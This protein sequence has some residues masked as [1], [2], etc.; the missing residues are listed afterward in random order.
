M[1]RNGNNNAAIASGVEQCECSDIY[2]GNSC[3]DPADGYFRWRNTTLSTNLL[4][5]L[6]GKVVPCEC[7]ERSDVCDKETGECKVGLKTI[8]NFYVIKLFK[9]Y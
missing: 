6:V 1:A 3:Q 4:E 2:T 7:N 5:D 9:N 8:S